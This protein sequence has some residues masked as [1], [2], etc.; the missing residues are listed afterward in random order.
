MICTVT[1]GDPSSRRT[2]AFSFPPS[3]FTSA[4]LRVKAPPEDFRITASPS[5]S[6]RISVMVSARSVS[7]TAC[8]PFS[9]AKQV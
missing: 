8:S 3:R 4:P 7:R 1:F 5:P 6:C 2:A 9:A